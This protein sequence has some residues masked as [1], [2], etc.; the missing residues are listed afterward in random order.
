MWWYL[1]KVF[2]LFKTYD[3]SI[4][5][6]YNNTLHNI[7][8]LGKDK[9]NKW[10]IMGVIYKIDCLDCDAS[11]VGQTKRSLKDRVKEHEINKNLDSVITLHLFEN[12][13]NFNWKVL[14][15]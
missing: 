5:S 3:I 9:C 15:F 11:Y 7:I 13:H 2:N 10:D 12:N 1:P 8:K 4:V 6:S 14:R